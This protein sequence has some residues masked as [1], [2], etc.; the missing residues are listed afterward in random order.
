MLE[1]VSNESGVGI[2]DGWADKVARLK[3]AGF[4]GVANR[5]GMHAEFG[6]D[7]ADLPMLGVKVAADAGAQFF[8]DHARIPSAAQRGQEAAV[9]VEKIRDASADPATKR[10]WRR[11]GS[12]VTPR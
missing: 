12:E 11:C 1:C 3:A 8:A 10:G 6:G 4:D 5:I 2:D 7:G 9:G